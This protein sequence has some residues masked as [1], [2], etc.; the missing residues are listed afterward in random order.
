MPEGEKK[1]IKC[2]KM[3][4]NGSLRRFGTEWKV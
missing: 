1:P 3:A 4:G 2:V